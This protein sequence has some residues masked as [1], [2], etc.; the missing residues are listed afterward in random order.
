MESTS[1][2]GRGFAVDHP[3]ARSSCVLVIDDDPDTLLTYRTIL[4]VA[5]YEIVTALSGTEGVAHAQSDPDYRLILTDLRLPDMSGLEV[6]AQV[7]LSQPK[8]P[9]IVMSAWGSSASELASRRLGAADF[10]HKSFE[11][12]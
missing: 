8:V 5:G 2:R 1:R 12:N 4:R 7:S 6:L 10:Y 11:P 3:M 9:V